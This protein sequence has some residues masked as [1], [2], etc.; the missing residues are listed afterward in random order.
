M[1]TLFAVVKKSG[2]V[3]ICG[4]FKGHNKSAAS[5]GS[6]SLPRIDDIL[7]RYLEVKYSKIDL[8]QAYL[9]LEMKEGIKKVL[10][11]KSHRGLYQYNRML[12]V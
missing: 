8:R 9:Q 11:N 2:G 1:A 4:D 6:I 5:S 7:L 10:D 12:F 3:R